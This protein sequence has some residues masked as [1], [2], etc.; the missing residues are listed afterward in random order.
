[1]TLTLAWWALP[2]ALVFVGLVA[3]VVCLI[4]SGRQSGMLG[5]LFEGLL[6]IALFVICFGIAGGIFVGRWMA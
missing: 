3:P 4:W 6:G 2:I 1:M 5:G